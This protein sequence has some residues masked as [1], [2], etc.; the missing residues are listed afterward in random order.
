MD[1]GAAD[2][3]GPL[4]VSVSGHA[5]AGLLL[6]AAGIVLRRSVLYAVNDVGRAGGMLVRQIGGVGGAAAEAEFIVQPGELGN[7][8]GEVVARD[9][10][11]EFARGEGR[12]LVE[13][14]FA[15]QVEEQ[16]VEE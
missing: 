12:Q 8:R 14:P 7:E 6:V 15:H 4:V 10:R 11:G 2:V 3:A 5:V 16:V 13:A 1:L 9:A